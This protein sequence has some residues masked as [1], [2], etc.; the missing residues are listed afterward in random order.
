MS[1]TL[2]QLAANVHGMV[3]GDEKSHYRKVRYA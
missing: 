3:K 2:G 1:Y